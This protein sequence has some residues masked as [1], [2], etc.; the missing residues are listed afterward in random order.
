MDL[1]EVIGIKKNPYCK[2]LTKVITCPEVISHIKPSNGLLVGASKRK[3]YVYSLTTFNLIYVYP[4]EQQTVEALEA[5]NGQIFVALSDR[6]IKIFNISESMLKLVK[7]IDA[8]LP[9]ESMRVVNKNLVVS[10]KG[11]FIVVDLDSDT[12]FKEENGV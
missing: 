4:I 6:T 5:R 1:A 11:S 10:R 8:G 2:N 7:I 9:V 3:I 12:V